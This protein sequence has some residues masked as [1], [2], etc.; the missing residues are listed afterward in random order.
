MRIV[1]KCVMFCTSLALIAALSDAGRVGVAANAAPSTE[2]EDAATSPASGFTLH[3]DAKRHFPGNP[4]FIAHHW[5]RPATGGITECQLYDS[6]A[7]NA[8][9]VGVEV[10]VPTATWKTFNR[11]EQALWHY[12]RVEIPKVSAT[13]P[14]MSPAQAKKVVASMMETYGK[15]YLLWDPSA[16]NQPVGKPFVYVMK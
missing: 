12:H 13:L 2:T 4:N 9:L 14:G 15:I 6:D 5:C 7:A 16:N 11:S 10:V 8:R 1:I 3:I